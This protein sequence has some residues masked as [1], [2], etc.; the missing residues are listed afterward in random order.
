MRRTGMIGL[1][2]AFA[3]G[4]CGGTSSQSDV[5]FTRADGSTASFRDAIRAWCGPFDEDN[6]DVEAVHVL[7]GALPGNESPGSYWILDAVRAD[8]ARD[9]ETALPNSFTYTEPRAAFVFVFDAEDR[10]NELSSAEEESS[11]TL[12]VE[13]DGCEAGDSVEVEFDDVVLGSEYHDLQTMSVTGTVVAA[14]GEP[15]T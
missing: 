11:G 3:L 7:A 5:E 13:S 10:E 2:V 12:R 4:G 15:P 1:L 8:I 9:P 14:I 6:E